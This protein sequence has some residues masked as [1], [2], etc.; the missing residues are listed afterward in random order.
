MKNTLR[1]LISLIAPIVL[2]VV[3][4]YLIVWFEHQ[5]VVPSL[6]SSTSLLIVGLV[7][8]FIGLVL[9]ITTIRMFILIG[10]GTIMPWD[11]TKKLIIVS[12]YCYVR[13]PMIL[14]III[15]QVGEA[16]QF[17]SYGIAVLAF[18]N[19]VLNTVYFIF[20]EEPGLEKRF[21]AEYVVYKKNVP[22]W[23]PRLK[24]WQPK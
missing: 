2:C 9:L 6:T 24:P 4:P 16:I 17:A 5:S 10:N 19:F 20:S 13:N 11:P 23:I 14:S 12:L 15:I 18:A 1:H 7:I 21:G 8:G 22:R 3:F